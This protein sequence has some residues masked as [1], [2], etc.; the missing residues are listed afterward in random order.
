MIDSIDNRGQ[1]FQISKKPIE[2]IFFP[3]LGLSK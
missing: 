2:S 3:E 1:I